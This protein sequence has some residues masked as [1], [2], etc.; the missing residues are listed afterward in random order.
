[1]ILLQVPFFLK[2]N[3]ILGGNPKKGKKRSFKLLQ[4]NCH[5][6][7]Y[8]DFSIKFFY[9]AHCSSLLCLDEICSLRSRALSISLS[10]EHHSRS[11]YL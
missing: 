9:H 10:P 11:I 1:M 5:D 6:N 4:A 7:I 2:K 8:L 3:H